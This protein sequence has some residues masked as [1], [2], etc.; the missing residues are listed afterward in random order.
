MTKQYDNYLPFLETDKVSTNNLK[1]DIKGTSGRL[2]NVQKYYNC[3]NPSVSTVNKF[4]PM[5]YWNYY[6]STTLIHRKSA[7]RQK[8]RP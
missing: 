7:N 4:Y 3:I 6:G 8:F 1:A 5:L 2:E